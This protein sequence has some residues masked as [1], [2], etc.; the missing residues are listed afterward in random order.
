ML[1]DIVNVLCVRSIK[2]DFKKRRYVPGAMEPDIQA[3]ISTL[4]FSH[5]MYLLTPPKGLS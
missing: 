5:G 1:V 2:Q 3:H 4:T